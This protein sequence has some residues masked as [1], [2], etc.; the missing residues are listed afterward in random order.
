MQIIIYCGSIFNNDAIGNDVLIQYQYLNNYNIFTKLYAISVDNSTKELIVSKQEFI[1][2]I[3]DR[4]NILLIHYGSYWDN[5]FEHIKTAKCKVILKYHNITPANFFKNYN[6]YLTLSLRDSRKKLEEIIQSG[7]IDYYW[8]DSY[9]NAEELIANNVDEKNIK[10]IPP[11]HKIHDFDNVKIDTELR[12]QLNNGAYQMLFVGRVAPNKGHKHLIETIKSYKEE[13]G[14][15]IHL[16]IIG[17]ISCELRGYYK[18]LKKLIKDYKLDDM[19]SFYDHVTF[20]QL[21]TFYATADLFLLMSEH[22]GFC[23]PILEAQYHNIPIIALDRAAVKETL[24][25]EQLIYEKI[26][27]DVFASA[28]Y[29][30]TTEKEMHTYLAKQGYNNFLKYEGAKIAEL[31]LTAVQDIIDMKE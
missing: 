4:D 2:L 13:Y 30:L 28:I 10:I 22:E 1:D 16:N 12:E 31:M 18:E 29:T 7:F 5:L 9:Y 3:L 25:E 14:N 6:K 24:G 15:N 20:E 23:V 21:N 19:I 26:D 27:Y 17:S 8:V 11:F